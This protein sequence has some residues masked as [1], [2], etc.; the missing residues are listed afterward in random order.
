MAQKKKEVAAIYKSLAVCNIATRS[1]CLLEFHFRTVGF[2]L[3]T[4]SLE[5]DTL[6]RHI[7]KYKFNMWSD[8]IHIAYL[9]LWIRPVF[10][11]GCPVFICNIFHYRCLGDFIVSLA[12]KVRFSKVVPIL[13]QSRLKNISACCRQTKTADGMYR[14]DESG[15]ML[16]RQRA[17]TAGW[18][19]DRPCDRCAGADYVSDADADKCDSLRFRSTS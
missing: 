12:F 14:S 6:V 2:V 4:V 17:G 10:N 8:Q 13:S 11:E 19:K 3:Q 18:D 15:I 7:H 16:Y 5:E 9:I 1:C